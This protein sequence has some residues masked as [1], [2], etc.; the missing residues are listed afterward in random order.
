MALIKIVQNLYMRLKPIGGFVR[1]YIGGT[2]FYVY[3]DAEEATTMTRT[4]EVILIGVS[5]GIL[6][7]CLIISQ[8]DWRRGQ[9]N[10]G[11]LQHPGQVVLA[12]ADGLVP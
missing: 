6:L 9:G 10:P 4:G 1:G 5:I 11:Q 12:G 8:T 7:I 2:L 3:G